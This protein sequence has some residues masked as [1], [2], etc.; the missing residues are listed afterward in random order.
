MMMMMNA[1]SVTDVSFS[2]R[3]GEGARV[4]NV[5]SFAALFP[6]T[7][8]MGA[9]SAAKKASKGFSESL[10]QEFKPFG[11]EVRRG[12]GRFVRGDPM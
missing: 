8:L 7:M 6:G 4:V 5:S 11:I 1:E 3:A 9:Y 12:R 2:A 10:H